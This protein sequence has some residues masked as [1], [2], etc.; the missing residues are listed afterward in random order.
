MQSEKCEV[1]GNCRHKTYDREENAF[2]CDNEESENY[3]LEI[4]YNDSCMDI[5]LE[6]DED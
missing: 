5:E 3:G 1:C 4:D 2:T 6:E